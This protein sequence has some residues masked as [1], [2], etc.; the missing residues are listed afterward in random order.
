VLS[1]EMI[2][3]YGGPEINAP[4]LS[5]FVAQLR[6]QLDDIELQVEVVLTI[7]E[8]A[9]FLQSWFAT[10]YVHQRE[11]YKDFDAFV[12]ACLA[13]P[14]SGVF[15]TLHYAD[16]LEVLAATLPAFVRIRLVPYELLPQHGA[17]AFVNAF[18]DIASLPADSSILHVDDSAAAQMVNQSDGSHRVRDFPIKHRLLR[19]LPWAVAGY[20]PPPLNRL[21][22]AGVDS[23]FLR[24]IAPTETT[25]RSDVRA[26]LTDDQR[27]GVRGVYAPGNR[28]LEKKLGLD[29]GGLGY[30]V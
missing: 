18:L 3:S 29:L 24:R 22:R 13:S 12:N 2:L 27:R 21:I 6:A 16:V 17:R 4:L 9:D 28:E 10:D 30:A 5:Y 14:T 11:H 1:D 19:G 26:E 23:E 15:G 7:R 8:Q 20:A 25:R